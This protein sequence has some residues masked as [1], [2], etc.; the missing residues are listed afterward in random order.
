MASMA[1]V[2]VLNETKY[3]DQKSSGVYTL[4]SSA[5]NTIIKTKIRS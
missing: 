4:L 1:H 5:V 2:V 3:E